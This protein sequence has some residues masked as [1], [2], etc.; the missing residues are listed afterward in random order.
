MTRH[1]APSITSISPLRESQE[2]PSIL[3]P[4]VAS[5]TFAELL[6]DCEEDRTLRLVL[7]R[8]VARERLLTELVRRR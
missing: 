1:D 7:G 6:I 3:T 5:R 4:P 8:D 2:E